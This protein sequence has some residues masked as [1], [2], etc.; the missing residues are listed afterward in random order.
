[1]MKKQM[2]VINIVGARPNFMKMG[3]IVEEM[4][5]SNFSQILIHTGQHYDYKMSK[6]FFDDLGLPRPHV[7]L[8][9]GSG[10]HAV[11][12]GEIM[13]GIESVFIKEKPALVLVVGDV[14]STLACAITASKLRIPVAHVE[15]G[16]RSFDRGM[17]EEINRV[18]T[19]AVSDYLFITED[20]AE[21]NLKREGI[22]Q[23][24]IFFVGNTMIDTLLKFR[25]RAQTMPV[26]I[27]GADIKK[28]TY[29]ILTM[30]RPSNIENKKNLRN[31][32]E[33]LKKISK[34]IPVIFPVHPRTLNQ[35]ESAGLLSYFSDPGSGINHGIHAVDPMGYL[36]FLSLMTGA[37]LVFT[38][39][40]GIQEETTVLN[41]PCVTLR[42]NTER[43]VTVSMGSN[44]LVGADKEKIIQEAEKN[45]NGAKK[46]GQV[47]RLW[48]G[49]AAERIVKI[50]AGQFGD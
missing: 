47:P 14:N 40:G 8:S 22:A 21:I 37:K 15:A 34:N 20:S 31:I 3:P 18:L 25:E 43:P 16:L 38:D 19:D 36:E 28:Q 24:K 42:E 7:N 33:A 11:Q 6:L 9:V 10:S 50:L 49:K 1:M 12:T 48:D 17:P 26:L 46:C 4:E 13:K 44:V 27:N 41:I 35:I 32:L 2:K 5:K 30:H 29:S 23:E 45:L 39:S